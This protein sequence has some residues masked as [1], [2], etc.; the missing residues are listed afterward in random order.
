MD[1]GGTEV[2]RRHGTEGVIAKTEENLARWS[3]KDTWELKLCPLG[4]ILGDTF[5]QT[6]TQEFWVARS[7]GV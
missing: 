2:G 4:M 1:V 3:L 5:V 6:G 7:K